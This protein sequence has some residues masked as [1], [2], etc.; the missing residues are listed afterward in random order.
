MKQRCIHGHVENYAAPIPHFASGGLFKF[1]LFNTLEARL[2]FVFDV[3][4]NA[5][6][7]PHSD[8]ISRGPDPHATHR[9]PLL[10]LSEGNSGVSKG[11]RVMEVSTRP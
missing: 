8:P 3:L 9:C 10:M 1:L 11:S 2:G 7:V 6:S 4:G 5:E